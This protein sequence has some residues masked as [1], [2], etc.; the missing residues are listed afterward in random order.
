MSDFR[1]RVSQGNPDIIAICETWFQENALNPKFYPNECLVIKGYNMYRFDNTEAVRG[2]ILL[3]IKPHLDGGTCK[4]MMK[5]STLFKESAWHWVNIKTSTAITEKLLFGCVYRKGACSAANTLALNEII[6][7]S[8]ELSDLVTV[9]GDFNFPKISWG[10]TTFSEDQTIEDQFLCTLDMALLTQHVTSFTRKRGTDNPSLLDLVITDRQQ[11]IS[12]PHVLE[13]L[14]NSDHGLVTWKSTF[15][16]SDEDNI[17][18][19]EPKPNFFKGKYTHM[20]QDK[21]YALQPFT[22]KYE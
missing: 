5:S 13:P 21:I 9:C 17:Y 10:N 16:Y 1:V 22:Y 18:V 20:K 3:Y 6:C 8:A 12:K 7:K 19:P 4:D 15:L 14:E 2:G 11:T